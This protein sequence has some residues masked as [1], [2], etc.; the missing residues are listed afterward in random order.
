MRRLS[1]DRGMPSLRAAAAK[2]FLVHHLGE[3]AHVVEVLHPNHCPI[4][5]TL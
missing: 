2:P 3:E 5:R 1:L 4:F